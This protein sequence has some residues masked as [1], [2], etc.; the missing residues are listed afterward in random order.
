MSSDSTA[1]GPI[2]QEGVRGFLHR[3]H[4]GA[5]RGLVLTHGAGG[6]CNASILLAVAAAGVTVHAF[7]AMS[8]GIGCDPADLAPIPRF[9]GNETNISNMRVDD[10]RDL[11]ALSNLMVHEKLDCV[12]VSS[13]WS[14]AQTVKRLLTALQISACARSG[15][16][17][18]CVLDP[19][20]SGL[21]TVR[22]AITCLGVALDQS[23]AWRERI[24]DVGSAILA[25]SVASV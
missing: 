25:F 14:R 21:L 23:G 24:L 12:F 15:L 11:A 19:Q 5:D 13:V 22:A 10:A 3:P 2:E 1:S 4:G 18:I 17:R 9:F 16:P 7:R 6:D 8:E 20:P